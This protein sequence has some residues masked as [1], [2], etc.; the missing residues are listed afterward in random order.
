MTVKSLP[1]INRPPTMIASVNDFTIQQV[2]TGYARRFDLSMYY[3]DPDVGEFG[4]ELTYGV[5][6]DPEGIVRIS[7]EG[8]VA[9]FEPVPMRKTVLPSPLSIRGYP[10][11]Q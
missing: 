1:H 7:V 10:I 6:S 3:S 4:D 2:G 5:S 9:V 8:S 11:R